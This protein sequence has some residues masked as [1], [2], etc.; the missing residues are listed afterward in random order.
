V[1]VIATLVL[2]GPAVEAAY[3]TVVITLNADPEQTDLATAV[4]SCVT[5]P[6]AKNPL[7]NTL[8]HQD[9]DA[10]KAQLET[11]KDKMSTSCYTTLKSLADS[12]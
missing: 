8:A 9:L 6:G 3:F 10:F 12:M 1:A 2:T 4:E 5:D 7:L 11:K